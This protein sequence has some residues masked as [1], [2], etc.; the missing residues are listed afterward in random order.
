MFL[1]YE[2]T[3]RFS[4]LDSCHVVGAKKRA[5]RKV[6]ERKQSFWRKMEQFDLDV[7]NVNDA[8]LRRYS[9]FWFTLAK[10]YRSL[11]GQNGTRSKAGSIESVR[12]YRSTNQRTFER[13]E[14]LH[15][16]VS[17]L[18]GTTGSPDATLRSKIRQQQQM[19]KMKKWKNRLQELGLRERRPPKCFKMRAFKNVSWSSRICFVVRNCDFRNPDFP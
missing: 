12:L 7:R 14:H 9:N 16:K 18:K 17:L 15:N 1:F 13:D 3:A 8:S 5:S 4:R 6:P 2:H 19:K 10:L 11:K